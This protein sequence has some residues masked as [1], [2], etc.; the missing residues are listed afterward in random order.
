[1]LWTAA[2]TAAAVTGIVA[3]ALWSVTGR[4]LTPVDT[5][6]MRTEILRATT[7]SVTLPRNDTSIRAGTYGLEWEEPRS[8][9]T[10]SAVLGDVMSTTGSTVTRELVDGSPLA[11]ERRHASW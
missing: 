8:G 6:P 2:G 9:E 4:F 1:M 5:L 7:S 3:G 10:G 11:Q